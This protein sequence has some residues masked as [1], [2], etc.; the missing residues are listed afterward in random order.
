MAELRITPQRISNNLLTNRL[1]CP[2]YH[3]QAIELEGHLN[4]FGDLKSLSNLVDPSRRITNGVRGPDLRTSK[5]LLVRLQDCN[6]WEIDFSHCLTISETQFVENHRCQLYEG[7]VVVAIGG[8][9]GNASIVRGEHLAVIGQHSAVLPHNP[10]EIDE[11]YL[12][13]YLNSKWGTVQLQRYVSGT[14]Q[15]GVN[16]EDLREILIPHPNAKVQKYIGDKVRQAER[17]RERSRRLEADFQDCLAKDYPE[18]FGPAKAQG[19]SSLAELDILTTNLNPGAYEPE[20]LRIRRYLDNNK[21]KPLCEVASI[22]TSVTSLYS[23]SDTYIGLD[24]ISSSSSLISPSTIEE[25]NVKGSTR[26]L[27][28]GPVI[29]K[30]RPYLNKVTYIPQGLEGALG[31]TELFCIKPKNNI[32]GW[33]LYGVLKLEST[34]RQLNPVSTGSTHPRVSREDILELM[35]PWHVNHQSL[36]QRLA[37]AQ[38]GY[39]LSEKLTTTAKFLTEALIEGKLSEVDLKIARECLEQG[40]ITFDRGIISRLTLKGI[41]RP[42]EPPL[43]PDLDVLYVALEKL[44]AS[45]TS[46]GLSLNVLENNHKAPSNNSLISFPLSPKAAESNG[47]Y[48]GSV[49]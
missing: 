12:L 36:G 47:S 19:K 25:E 45:D 24:T 26:I 7:D 16:L 46:N 17:L 8:Y 28:E 2:F 14:V 33:F 39:F 37:E 15:A 41:D 20:R 32:S 4:D 23:R 38:N 10:N 21:G 34:V 48:S 22:K 42:N 40:N 1:D 29:S 18:I 43:F 44:D 35:I 30:L 13:A 11:R 3:P 5:Y 27:E 49:P 31:S 6:D 9:V